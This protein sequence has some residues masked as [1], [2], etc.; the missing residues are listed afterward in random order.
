MDA[1]AYGDVNK[2]ELDV[3]GLFKLKGHRH[4]NRQKL[5][6]KPNDFRKSKS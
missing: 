5:V 3:V 4:P 1:D 2:H 6:H